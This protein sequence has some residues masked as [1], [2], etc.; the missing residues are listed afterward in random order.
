MTDVEKSWNNLKAE[1]HHVSERGLEDPDCF[2]QIRGL[3][4][5]MPELVLYD[6]WPDQGVA[7]VHYTTWKSA[8]DM[9]DP[10]QK[11]PVIRMYNYEQANDP[12]EGQIRPPEWE[13]LEEEA[14][15]SWLDEFLKND[16][17]NDDRWREEM[18]LGSTYGCS[19]SSGPSGDVEDDLTYWRLY[20]N[21]GQ[22]CSLKISTSQGLGVYKVRYRDRNFRDRSS[23]DEKEDEDVVKRLET[24]F[25]AG[26]KAVDSARS[27]EHRHFVGRT[28]A[29]I[30]LRVLYGYYHLIKHLAYAG[31]KEWRMIRVMP[32]PDKIRYD[33]PS[34][35]LVRRYVDGPALSNLLISASV[36][37]IG[38]TVPNRGAA[39]A[40]LEHLAKDKHQISPVMVKNSGK[41]YRQAPSPK[42][43]QV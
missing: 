23:S 10:N 6:D 25:E 14:R 41:A 1:L 2:L 29:E 32:R 9:F 35:D 3:I 34:E 20:G 38:P 5:R 31:E 40:Y 15:K 8:L 42:P 18:K 19:F 30:L 24:L 43:R 22:G 21:D 39:R 16:D 26:K 37:T 17:K 36:I 11:S 28:V 13:A 4:D 7:L 27:G 33:M 12:D